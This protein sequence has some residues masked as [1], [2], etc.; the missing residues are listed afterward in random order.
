MTSLFIQVEQVI[1]DMVDSVWKTDAKPAVNRLIYLDLKRKKSQDAQLQD[2]HLA[3]A[4]G[5][6]AP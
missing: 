5:Q 4:T 6:T 1:K 3:A 2:A